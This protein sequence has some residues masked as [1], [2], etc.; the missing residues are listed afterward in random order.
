LLVFVEPF[1]EFRQGRANTPVIYPTD[2]RVL[3]DSIPDEI[4]EEHASPRA[5]NS[6]AQEGTPRLGKLY[7]RYSLYASPHS[8]AL[9]SP[10]TTGLTST[11]P[12]LTLAE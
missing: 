6:L 7:S 9:F 12:L 8:V 3:G 5:N 1:L 4:P 2:W 11:A 10:R